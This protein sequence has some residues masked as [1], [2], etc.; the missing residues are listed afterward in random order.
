MTQIRL[1]RGLRAVRR[2][3]DREI[4]AEALDDILG[5]ARWTGSSK[6]TQPWGLIVIGD[7]D[8]LGRLARL[9]QYADHLAAAPLAV[10]ITMERAT[11]STE[12]DKGRLAQNI[13]L[14]AWAH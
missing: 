11:F 13:M 6:N 12:F 7:R 1:L 8:T 4:P 5:V 3:S 14:A 9:G 10:A 2:F